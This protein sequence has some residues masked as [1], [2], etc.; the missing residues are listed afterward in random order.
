M[1]TSKGHSFITYIYI[2]IH[3]YVY[4][5]EYIHICICIYICIYVCIHTQIL[6][7]CSSLPASLTAMEKR[8]MCYYH[9]LH[10]GW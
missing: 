1:T 5:Y 7:F 8:K 10:F 4:I 2:Y 6:Y 9:K 3:M